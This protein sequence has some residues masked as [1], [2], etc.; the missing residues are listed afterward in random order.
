MKYINWKLWQFC[1]RHGWSC[2]TNGLCNYHYTDNK[3]VVVGVDSVGILVKFEEFNYDQS[4]GK[5]VNFL[6]DKENGYSISVNYTGRNSNGTD[7]TDI[8]S[9]GEFNIK[10]RDYFINEGLDYD[11]FREI[12]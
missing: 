9:E 2:D 5:I 12:V 7:K 4:K 1:D 6:Y 8:I 11:L 3:S 10:L